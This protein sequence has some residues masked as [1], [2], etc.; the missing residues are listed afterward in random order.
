M[1]RLDAFVVV[2]PGLERLLADEL[3]QI[4]VSGRL[5]VEKGG[6]E[7][8]VTTRQLYAIHRWC[9]IGTRVLLR[10][11]TD[12]THRFDELE[13]LVGS[14]EWDSFLPAGEP[15][16]L[17][18]AS[19][20]S[21]LYHE[22]AIAERVER[23][24]DRPVTEDGAGVYV[25]IDR[26]RAT[27][28]IDASGAPLHHRG[29]RTEI[30]AAPLRATLAAAMLRAAGH[31]GSCPLVDPMAGSGT[32]PIEAA[33]SALLMPNSREFAFQR[34]PSFEPGTWASVTAGR[35]DPEASIAPILAAD[36]DAGAVAMIRAHLAASGV[37]RHVAVQQA[38]LAA[39]SWPD[40]PGLVVVNPPYG[41]RIGGADLR[42][43]Y[44]TL[45][46]RVG[47]GGHRLCVLT[48]DERLVRATGLD[49]VERFATSNGGI[50]VRCLMSQGPGPA[51]RPAS[52]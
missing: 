38:A 41:H 46:R 33:V 3:R 20:A 23:V 42:D 16:S 10:L 35:P 34:W 4:G 21:K 36:R 2:A 40:G 37:E 49:L 39:Q 15:V 45:G 43:L 13:H 50:P 17:H 28:S 18:V 47:D 26:N 7:V 25:R 48:P 8:G 5:R 22:G 9:R 19:Q 31:D 1:A 32:I 30:H 24:L 44:A 12:A 11:A 14:V 29:W 51:E 52:A 6:V 27:L